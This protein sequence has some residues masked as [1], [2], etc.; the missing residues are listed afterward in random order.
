MSSLLALVR[1]VLKNVSLLYQCLMNFVLSFIVVN[2]FMKKK[3][4]I[5]ILDIIQVN[6]LVPV[7]SS[8]RGF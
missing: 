3:N 8:L 2:L 7:Y 4:Q 6:M 1:I 5:F